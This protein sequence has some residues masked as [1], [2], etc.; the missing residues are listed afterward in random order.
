[1]ESKDMRRISAV[2][3]PGM[4]GLPAHADDQLMDF[5]TDAIDG[6][7]HPLISNDQ[8]CV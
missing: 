7:S 3:V 5:A 1:M 6:I 4:A 8:P 2:G